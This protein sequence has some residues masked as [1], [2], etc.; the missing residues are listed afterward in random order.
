MQIEAGKIE[1][2]DEIYKNSFNLL[3]GGQGQGKT[4]HSEQLIA[5]NRHNFKT[6]KRFS[7]A[8]TNTSLDETDGDISDLLSWLQDRVDH[9]SER[10][11]DAH[12]ASILL[13]AIREGRPDLLTKN[14]IGE[15]EIKRLRDKYENMNAIGKIEPA[16]VLIDD[17]GG[18]RQLKD[19]STIF[20]TAARQLR[21]LHLTVIFNAHRF[22]DLPPLVRNNT[23]TL[24]LHGGLPQSDLK[25]IWDER[26]VPCVRKREELVNNYYKVTEQP[27]QCLRIDYFG[28]QNK[29]NARPNE[30]ESS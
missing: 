23:Q 7:P 8:G 3:I 13:R 9:I 5:K 27:Y 30:E 25:Q 2:L 20:N 18:D 16:L 4:Y 28:R 1:P 29:N 10:K 14:K 12:Q 21:H 11:R 19:S 24:F 6:I 22:K 17:M 15:Q 26:G